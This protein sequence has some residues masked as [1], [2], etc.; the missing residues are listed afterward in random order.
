MLESCRAGHSAAYKETNMS[1]SE[2][3]IRELEVL[4]I[5]WDS[6][7][8][9]DLANLT[10]KDKKAGEKLRSLLKK[11]SD[12]LD[13][14]ESE[15]IRFIENDIDEAYGIIQKYYPE[16]FGTIEF[17]CLYLLE[18]FYNQV[19]Y[20]AKSSFSSSSEEEEYDEDEDSDAEDEEQKPELPEDIKDILVI[21][22]WYEQTRVV[23]EELPGWCDAHEEETAEWFKEKYEENEE[24]FG[25]DETAYIWDNSEEDAGWQLFLKEFPQAKKDLY[26][27]V[28]NI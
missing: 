6:G 18:E 19:Y 23:A 8:E 26:T 25:G 2:M 17:T 27:Y 4:V 21:D 5:G 14:P 7:L 12:C 11:Q 10:K 15:H 1:I 24:L 3:T 20:F 9:K 13:E 28:Y 22:D 16:Y